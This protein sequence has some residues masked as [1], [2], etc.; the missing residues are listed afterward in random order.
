MC[1]YPY[2]SQV[3][4]SDTNIAPIPLNIPSFAPEEFS[5][6]ESVESAHSALDFNERVATLLGII[7]PPTRMDSQAKYGSLAR[8]DGGAYLRMPTGVG[9]QEKIWVSIHL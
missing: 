3:A 9:Y 2:H 7:R 8:G 5:F 6:L 4:L 1:S